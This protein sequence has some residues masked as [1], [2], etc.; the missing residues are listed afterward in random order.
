MS[1]RTRYTNF[2]VGSSGQSLAKLGNSVA[3]VK[4]ESLEPEVKEYVDKA[5][6][7]LKDGFINEETYQ[8]IRSGAINFGARFFGEALG[9]V[10]TDKVAGAIATSVIE[11]TKR[12]TDLFLDRGM[13]AAPVNGNVVTI[14][15]PPS[16]L[17]NT[18]RYGARHGVPV[19]GAIIDFSLLKVEGEDTTDALVKTGAH[20]AISVGAGVT[21]AKLGT[22]IGTAFFPGAWTVIGAAVG[23][24]IGV[25]GSMAFDYIY[26]NGDKIMEGINNIG[27]SVV[28]SVKKNA[29]KVGDAVTGLF[30]KLGTVFG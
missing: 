12:T 4:V 18:V 30:G 10:V 6:Q 2:N 7:D 29:E 11:W 1:G 28:D 5:H 25:V 24:T 13:I 23:F 17:K 20:V 3:E 14:P 8:S 27:N 15:E 22:M 26:D 21:G 19:V 16:A 9:D